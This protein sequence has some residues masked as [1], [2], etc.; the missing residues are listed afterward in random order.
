MEINK[1]NKTEYLH[2]FDINAKNSKGDTI[3]HL[4]CNSAS[5]TKD[6]SLEIVEFLLKHGAD[7]NAKNEHDWTPL[8][9]T[10]FHSDDADIAELLLKHG[11]DPNAKNDIDWTPL[12]CAI[13][14]KVP[15]I[16]K[17]LLQNG[18]T[19]IDKRTEILKLE[20]DIKSLVEENEKL[21]R[22]ILLLESE[23]D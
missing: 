20:V 23:L 15:E 22:R 18:A 9:Y 7:P 1:Y 6:V 11:A 16:V 19:P 4:V 14:F 3:L 8:H 17:L 12:H 10:S 5:I 2:E 21:E 13:I